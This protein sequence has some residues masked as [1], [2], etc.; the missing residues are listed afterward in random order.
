M[1]TI[2][3]NVV[4][5]IASHFT[6]L[7]IDGQYKE[8][9]SLLCEDDKKAMSSDS[10]FVYFFNISKDISKN[11][12]KVLEIGNIN[13]IDSILTKQNDTLV[14]KIVVQVLDTAVF[15]KLKDPSGGIKLHK[16]FNFPKKLDTL[17]ICKII[18]HNNTPSIYL[19]LQ[20]FRKY[21][22][23]LGKAKQE[24]RD[25]VELT[26]VKLDL[27]RNTYDE[28]TGKLFVKV[29]NNC[30]TPIENVYFYLKV[31]AVNYQ[32][33]IGSYT[34]SP[35]NPGRD[36]IIDCYLF[37]CNRIGLLNMGSSDK[38]TIPSKNLSL[39]AD[40]IYVGSD[41]WGAILKKA[42]I[43]SN[44]NHTYIDNLNSICSK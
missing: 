20:S 7:I 14:F 3:F 5:L 15:W 26:P 35:L 43:E 22:E 34:M 10:F 17:G 8:A 39:E 33:S 28:T 9:Y 25:C 19:G 12:G 36:T 29:K 4:E 37:D 40:W 31:R 27:T 6:H 38:M 11:N 18:I 44:V 32:S 42:V 2:Y 30:K 16:G 41:Q 13:I 1:E 21:Q 24:Y 23:I